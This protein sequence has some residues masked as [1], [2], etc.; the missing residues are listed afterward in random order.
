MSKV[1]PTTKEQLIHYLLSH[2]SLGTY[3]R[4]FLTNLETG[5]L[6]KG[7]AVTTNQA[8]LLDKII[9]RYARQL[10]KNELNYQ[11]LILLEW[12]KPL[13][14]SAP[15][16][17]TAYAELS[18]D[19]IIIKT[20]YKAGFIKEL[21]AVRT[22]KWLKDEREWHINYNERNLKLVI[23]L[24]A[25]HYETINFCETIKGFLAEAENYESA[26]VWNPTLCMSNGRLLVA[27]I[28]E[29]LSNAINNVELDLTPKCLAELSSYGVQISDDIMTNELLKFAGTTNPKIEKAELQKLI[30]YLPAIGCESV[31][32]QSTVS[33][34]MDEPYITLAKKLEEKNIK[35]FTKNK[36]DTSKLS[37]YVVLYSLRVVMSDIDAHATKLIQVVNSEPV[38]IK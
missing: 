16:Y 11:E 24:V 35:V 25:E 28:N 3:D 8:A 4:R 6:G 7:K 10:S 12:S 13:I 1:K 17:T 20:P 9:A 26:R 18:N 31:I 2:I 27:S 15:E 33:H 23:F 36:V 38:D 22:A 34:G 5:F 37:N 30:E 29:P 14:E 32:L 19:K 21:R